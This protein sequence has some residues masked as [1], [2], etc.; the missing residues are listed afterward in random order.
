MVQI[1]PE[2]GF[3][4][5]F[6]EAFQ[7]AFQSGL[8]SFLDTNASKQQQQQNLLD[9]E[10]TYKIIEER[11]GKPYADLYKASPVGARTELIKQGIEANI[12]GYDIKKLLGEHPLEA[13]AQEKHESEFPEYQ[14]D[15]KGKIGKE[16][17]KYH[18]ELRKENTP[19]YQKA[20]QTRKTAQQDLKDFKR[21]DELGKKIPQ[22]VSRFFYDKNGNIRPYAQVLKLVPPEAEEYVKL[23][24]NFTSRI[25]DSFGSQISNFDI[26]TFLNRFPKLS[27]SEEGRNLINKRMQITAEADEIMNQAI[28]DVY[29][30]YG[31]GKITQEDALQ[32]AEE[33][34]ERR[35]MELREQGEEVDQQMAQ[36]LGETASQQQPV[37][38]TQER[39]S[40]QEI[41]G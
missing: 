39:R 1:L 16:I 9:D 32:I 34:G 4:A 17:T 19:I 29:R 3:K 20:R 21:L 25:K 18:S 28:E 7:P 37:Q 41:L 23:I 33:I 11:W 14:L 5:A 6:K 10:E 8:Q 26:Q 24:Y 22:G 35:L 31:M 13:E 36:L 40:L 12:R 2:R 27:N 15:T 30:H 38:Q